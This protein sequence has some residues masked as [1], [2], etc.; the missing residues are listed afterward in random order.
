M[1]SVYSGNTVRESKNNVIQIG[2]IYRKFVARTSNNMNT[3]RNTIAFGLPILLAGCMDMNHH[4]A[5]AQAELNISYP[6]AYVVNGESNSLSVIDLASNAV[7]ET[8]SFGA[9]STT[10]MAGMK[11][12]DMVM[13]PHHIY[14]SPDGNRLGVGVPGMDLSAGHTGS[15]SGMKGRVLVVNP[16]T[17]ALATNQQ[18]PVMNHNAVF[19]PDGSEIWTSQMTDAGKVLVY[20]ANTM[21]L[22]KTIEVG[23]EPA[24]V[25]MS[26]NGQYAFVANGKSNTVTA[27]RVS[28]KT[29]AKTIPVGDDP[30]GAWP[31]ANNRMY[32]DNE[33]GK[34][35]SVIDV[36][37]L[38][39]VETINLG[40][41]PGYVA[42]HPVRNELWV[43]QAGGSSVAIFENMGGVWMNHAQVSTGL[44]AHAIVFTKDAQT[45]YV[46]NQGAGTV[47]VINVAARNKI[48]DIAV[49]KKPN[50]LVLKY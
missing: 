42:F 11:M 9:A 47:S 10:D 31:G 34:S 40:F 12:N 25:T 6:A 27:I 35:I 28:D 22:K 29:V 37:K 33:K 5:P 18:T 38:A 39:V 8:I 44:D 43:S 14:L 17:G 19:S 2:Y 48:K 30:V 45:A 50:G 21:A 1:H 15:V 7:R 49:G 23:M 16:K 32:V 3:L 26:A 20:D 46:T 4:M 36:D 24:E 13:W 41:T